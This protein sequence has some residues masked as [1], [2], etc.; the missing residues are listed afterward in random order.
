MLKSS[1]ARNLEK[2][3]IILTANDLFKSYEYEY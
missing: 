2:Q 3:I 1:I